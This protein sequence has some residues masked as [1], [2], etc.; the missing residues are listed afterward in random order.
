M[1]HDYDVNSLRSCGDEMMKCT[2]IRVNSCVLMICK[3]MR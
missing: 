3:R 2:R 1:V